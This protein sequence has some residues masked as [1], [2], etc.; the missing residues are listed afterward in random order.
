MCVLNSINLGQ[1]SAGLVVSTIFRGVKIL[2]CR[3]HIN[4]M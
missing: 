2:F 3:A 4:I 1:S